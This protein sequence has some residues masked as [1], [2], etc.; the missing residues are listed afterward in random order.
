MK[1]IGGYLHNG[2]LT[3]IGTGMGRIS[4]QRV[5][6]GGATTRPVDM[7]QSNISYSTSILTRAYAW[8]I[9]VLF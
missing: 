1:K 4:I 8:G 9:F 3:N 6:Y 5:G 2:Y 7:C